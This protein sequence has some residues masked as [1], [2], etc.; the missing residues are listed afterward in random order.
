MYIFFSRGRECSMYDATP[1]CFNNRKSVSQPLDV[2][3]VSQVHE[4]APSIDHV[5]LFSLLLT[6][7]NQTEADM[8]LSFSRT[9]PAAASV[10]AMRNA[11]HLGPHHRTNKQ[12][13]QPVNRARNAFH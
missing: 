3:A 9:N 6:K 1:I 5:R 4:S 8:L 12:A 13:G 11:F 7:Y 10:G 2:L